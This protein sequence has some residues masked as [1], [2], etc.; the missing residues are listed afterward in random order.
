[1]AALGENMQHFFGTPRHKIRTSVLS[2]SIRRHTKKYNYFIRNKS[3]KPALPV[4]TNINYRQTNWPKRREELEI[5]MR[6][7]G[8]YFRGIS[9]GQQR[10]RPAGFNIA[11]IIPFPNTSDRSSLYPLTLTRLYFIMKDILQA[12]TRE[13]FLDI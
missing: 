8:R 6:V 1:M 3:K 9:R 13:T 2:T 12:S 10:R 11:S 7:Y 5:F 4:D